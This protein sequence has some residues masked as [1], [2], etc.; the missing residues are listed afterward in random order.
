MNAALINIIIH[1]L[2]SFYMLTALSTQLNIRPL[3]SKTQYI[4]S[5]Y[6]HI[7]SIRSPPL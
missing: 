6:S 5:M 2:Y 4:L 7:A 3:F 1:F